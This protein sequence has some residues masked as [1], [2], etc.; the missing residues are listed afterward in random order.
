MIGSKINI[1]NHLKNDGKVI[2]NSKVV[3]LL[4]AIFLGALGVHRF[5]LG[6]KEIAFIQSVIFIVALLIFSSAILV[7]WIWSIIDAVQIFTGK[8]KTI[9]GDMLV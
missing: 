7:F 6:Y 8:L 5:Y 2:R 1:S 3:A 4:L 9:S